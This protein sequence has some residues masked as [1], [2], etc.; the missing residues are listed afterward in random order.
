MAAATAI[1]GG[2]SD[3]VG[4]GSGGGRAKSGTDCEVVLR[5]SS[6]VIGGP[7]CSTLLVDV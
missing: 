2:F 7:I 1:G 3:A 6:T 4:S 5:V